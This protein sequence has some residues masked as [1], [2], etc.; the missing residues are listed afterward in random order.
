MDRSAFKEFC[1]LLETCDNDNAIFH[2]GYAFMDLTRKQH[3][4]VYNILDNRGFPHT[5]ITNMVGTFDGIELSTGL[6]L[7]K[8]V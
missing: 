2:A 4:K 1:I 8:E 6:V 7:L 5:T 3:D